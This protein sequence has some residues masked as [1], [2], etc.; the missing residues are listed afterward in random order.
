M[1]QNSTTITYTHTFYSQFYHHLGPVEAKKMIN[2]CSKHRS[3]FKPDDYTPEG[4]FCT[5]YHVNCYVFFKMSTENHLTSKV[6]GEWVSRRHRQQ[7][8]EHR[9]RWCT[10]SRPAG[11]I[12]EIMKL[13][14]RST[15]VGYGQL[16]L[17]NF[18]FVSVP[19]FSLYCC[20][21]HKCEIS[22]CVITSQLNCLKYIE[23]SLLTNKILIPTEW[24]VATL[25]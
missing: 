4:Q 13:I 24:K 5:T 16:L 9:S 12:T 25:T 19:S 18:H 10:T 11:Q 22:E 6:F 8:T 3:K 15:L 20:F 21:F 7:T 1:S 14:L 2:K 17:N 23:E